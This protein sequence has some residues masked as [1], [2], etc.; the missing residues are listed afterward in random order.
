MLCPHAWRIASARDQWAR[1]RFAVIGPLLASPPQPSE[2]QA[3]LKAL[4]E[5]NWQHPISGLPRRFGVST[6]ERWYYQARR[7]QDP[8]S[9]LKPKLRADA[10][11]SGVLSNALK[12]AITKQ[13]RAHP[14]WKA[15]AECLC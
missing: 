1:L 2:L 14:A 3:A 12:T 9:A 4:A 7:Q 11:R 13:H 8:V 15:H 5:R 6:I 10:G